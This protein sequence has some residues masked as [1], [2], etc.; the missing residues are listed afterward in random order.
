MNRCPAEFAAFACLRLR[1]SNMRH[2]AGYEEKAPATRGNRTTGWCTSPE[3]S[4]G[5]HGAAARA[6]EERRE[7]AGEV[8]I[9]RAEGAPPSRNP[10]GKQRSQA[11]NGLRHDAQDLFQRRET[12]GHLA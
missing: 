7:L 8:T 5:S 11:S 1:A 9:S 6:T 4:P 3:R 10:T 2:N 12:P